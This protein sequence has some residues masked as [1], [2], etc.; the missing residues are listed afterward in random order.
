MVLKKK[1]NLFNKLL[2]IYLILNKIKKKKKYQFSYFSL[3]LHKK[4]LYVKFLINCK[5]YNFSTG[6]LL[7]KKFK[8]IKFFKK[9]HKNIGYSIN[10][11]N[12]KFS[13][14]ISSILIFYC[15]N[16]TFKQYIWLKKFYF[17]I[18]PNIYYFIFSGS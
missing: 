7:G 10:I 9:S 2:E 5:W 14:P 1:K 8:R 16:F 4:L 6:T 17:L 11:L 3:F 12:K 13:K 18:K 15:K